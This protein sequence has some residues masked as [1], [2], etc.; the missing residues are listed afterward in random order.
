VK[1]SVR[2]IIVIALC[3]HSIIYADNRYEIIDAQSDTRYYIPAIYENPYAQSVAFIRTGNELCSGE[4]VYRSKRYPIVKKALEKMLGESLDGKYVPTIAMVASGGGFRAMIGTLGF[5]NG[6]DKIGLL[7]ATTYMV[8]LSGSTWLMAPWVSS[9]LP[10]YAFKNQLAEKIEKG[11]KFVSLTKMKLVIDALY[12]KYLY[13]QPITFVDLYGT[14]LANALLNDF[15]D[16]RQ[17][18]HLS[19][20]VYKIASAHYPYPIYTA[21]RAEAYAEGQWYEFTPYEVGGSWLGCYVPS[22]G[23]GR[24]FD[25]GVS[26]NNAPEQSLGFHLGTFGSGMGANF[27]NMYEYFKG[28]L[29][30]RIIPDELEEIF[31]HCF[32]Q[33]RFVWSEVNNFTFNFEKS[34]LAQQKTLRLV[35]AGALPGFNLPY[36]PI[37]GERPERKADIIIFL[38]MSW[39]IY[40]AME[41]R[42]AERYAR[43]HNLKFPAINYVGIDSRTLSIFADVN[44]P[45]VPMVFYMPL[46]NDYRMWSTL[47][48]DNA[49][50]EYVAFVYKF[51]IQQACQ[52]GFASTFN[53]SYK[54]EEFYRLSSLTEFNMI[55]NKRPILH[56]IAWMIANKSVNE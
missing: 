24:S 49:Y 30:E 26:V 13:D 4:H 31:L 51:D 56:A 6:A 9:G 36:P 37:S 52:D 32:G 3:S 15:G 55:F 23:Y 12:A 47:M 17:R 39:P 33:T 41:L 7:D 46:T 2:S 18:V 8:G 54:Q 43:D 44:D 45:D 22:W 10:M 27:E 21:V 38:D 53:F 28:A 11:I 29:I 1:R 42:K 14:L 20:Q 34:P 35:D 25:N 19:D 16:S 5:L 48:Y 40:G 50:Q